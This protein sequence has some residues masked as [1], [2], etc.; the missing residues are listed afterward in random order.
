MIAIRATVKGGFSVFVH[1]QSQNW[2]LFFRSFDYK[3]FRKGLRGM[4]FGFWSAFPK[5]NNICHFKMSPLRVITWPEPGHKSFYIPTE[6]Q[7]H[8]GLALNCAALG[9]DITIPSIC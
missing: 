7:Q 3:L 8:C 2:N 4:S 6:E 9:P 5:G 1:L